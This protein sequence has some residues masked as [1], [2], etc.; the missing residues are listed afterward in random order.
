MTIHGNNNGINNYYSI[1]TAQIKDSL[2]SSGKYIL[3]EGDII[4]IVMKNSNK[5]IAQ[6]SSIIRTNGK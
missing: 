1:Y 5:I 2:K 6:N 3:R 4:S